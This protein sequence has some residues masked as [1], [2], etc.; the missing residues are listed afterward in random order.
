MIKSVLEQADSKSFSGS[1]FW[2]FFED[3]DDLIDV[4][5]GFGNRSDIG[6]LPF[7]I[8]QKDSFQGLFT[9]R[10]ESSG[11]VV[12]RLISARLSNR[13]ERRQYA[14]AL[15]AIRTQDEPDEGAR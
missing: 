4:V 1:I 3:L 6:D 11:G 10:V 8:D 5:V 15:E 2:L 14:E 13:K 12:R 7:P 9:D